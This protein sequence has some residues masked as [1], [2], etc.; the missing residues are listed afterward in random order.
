MKNNIISTIALLSLLCFSSI[1]EVEGRSGFSILAESVNNS[2]KGTFNDKADPVLEGREW[3]YS[4]L[5]AG[6]GINYQIAMGDMFS[7]NPFTSF[8]TG[9]CEF[10]E[11]EWED[12]GASYALKKESRPCGHLIN[13]LQVRIWIGAFFIGAYSGYFFEESPKTEDDEDASLNFVGMIGR[14]ETGYGGIAGIEFDG[15][16]FLAVQSDLV[17]FEYE[18]FD[19]NLAGVRLQFGFRWK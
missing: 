15:G 3:R 7:L 11:L 17:T 16:F 14:G 19:S 2:M 12:Q 6:L 9:S 5:E 8:S 4:S 18:E 13:G 10:E 1:A